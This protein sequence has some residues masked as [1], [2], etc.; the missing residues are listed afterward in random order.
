MFEKGFTAGFEF[1]DFSG[2]DLEEG[3][4]VEEASVLSFAAV[5][6]FESDFF[7]DEVA[8]GFENFN[9]RAAVRGTFPGGVSIV[10]HSNKS[11]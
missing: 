10:T 8:L 6:V 7:F 4:F 2:P 11:N 5:G 3:D 1:V 9:R